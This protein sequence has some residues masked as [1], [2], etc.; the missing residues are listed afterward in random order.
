MSLYNALFGVNGNAGL[1]LMSLGITEADVP[2]F[3]DCYLDDDRLVIHT[4]TG[5]GNRDYYES[6]E[7]CR[8]EYPEYFK[9]G[10]DDPS[11]PWNVDL[12]KLPGYLYDRDDDYDSTYANFYFTPAEGL[13]TLCDRLTNGEKTVPPAER[14]QKLLEDLKG[15]N[16]SPEAAKAL[17]VGKKI[18]EQIEQGNNKIIEV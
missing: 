14:W 9:G 13:V 15:D 18:F 1:L 7:S 5:G 3:R 4:R 17:E 16:D 10:D 12:R 2:R 11:G 6:E 8:D